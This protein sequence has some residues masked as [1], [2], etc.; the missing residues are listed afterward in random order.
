MEI[1]IAAWC[2]DS[3][4]RRT[5]AIV[6]RLGISKVQIDYGHPDSHECLERPDVVREIRKVLSR[7]CLEVS[8]I[9]VNVLNE[10]GMSCSPG[11]SEST[12]CRAAIKGAICAARSLTVD[13]LILPSFDKGE[14]RSSKDFKNTVYH[15]AYAC[16]LSAGSDLRLATES[17]LSAKLTLSLLSHIDDERLDVLID[18]QNPILWGHDASALVRDLWPQVSCDIHVKDG[19]DGV[20]GNAELFAGDGDLARTLN[21]LLV[22]GFDGCLVLENEYHNTFTASHDVQRDLAALERFGIARGLPSKR[23]WPPSQ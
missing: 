23:E 20:M 9:A 10:L 15:L 21:T 19:V 4:I 17:T 6:A 7:N 18:T 14:V 2:F 5:A 8:A 16:S 1:G 13:L 22:L 11:T 12:A 3:P